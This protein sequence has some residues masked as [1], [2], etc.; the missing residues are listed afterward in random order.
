MSEKALAALVAIIGICCIT[1]LSVVM[2]LAQSGA[3]K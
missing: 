2:I 1:V 3:F